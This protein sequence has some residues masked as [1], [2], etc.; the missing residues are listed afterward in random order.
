[1]GSCA[2]ATG[3]YVTQHREWG[4]SHLTRMSQAWAHRRGKYNSY[5]WNSRE[6]GRKIKGKAPACPG[7]ISDPK[8][9]AHRLLERAQ[10]SQARNWAR[11]SQTEEDRR[12]RHSGQDTGLEQRFDGDHWAVEESM[13]KLGEQG[14]QRSDYGG[15]WVVNLRDLDLPRGTVG[16]RARKGRGS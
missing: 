12:G 8:A 15:Y 11:G 3:Y 2:V 14:R 1:M 4:R 7:G 6:F 13:G 16:A 5:P 10:V 9:Q